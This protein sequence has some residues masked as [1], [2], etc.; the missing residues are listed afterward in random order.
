MR[1]FLG[2][3]LDFM[4][5]VFRKFSWTNLP[6]KARHTIHYIKRAF[7]CGVSYFF[8]IVC[9]CSNWTVMTF[10]IIDLLESVKIR[11]IKFGKF[12]KCGT[13]LNELPTLAELFFTDGYLTQ[14]KH[15]L[16]I[17]A[18]FSFCKTYLTTFDTNLSQV[19]R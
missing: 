18:I 6:K 1:I 12:D 7:I 3:Q 11:Q 2:N 4:N 19:I 13:L 9:N 10:S 14:N 5:L 15:L 16:I 8:R 17:K